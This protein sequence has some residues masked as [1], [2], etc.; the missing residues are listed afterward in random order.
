MQTGKQTISIASRAPARPR[1]RPLPG[2]LCSLVCFGPTRRAH[3]QGIEEGL[4]LKIRLVTS[5][6]SS[7]GRAVESRSLCLFENIDV[8]ACVC[9][10]LGNRDTHS[11][12]KLNIR[13]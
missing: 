4:L 5:P 3:V 12:Q 2:M 9:V 11:S 1:T 10:C 8:R 13:V 7:S 6:P